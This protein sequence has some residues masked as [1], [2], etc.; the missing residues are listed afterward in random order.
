MQ[1][2]GNMGA[3]YNRGEADAEQS[4][5]GGAQAEDWLVCLFIREVDGMHHRG[6]A[7]EEKSFEGGSA[8]E[9]S[10]LFHY[11]CEMEHEIS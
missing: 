11:F 5:K 8:A 9:A 3:A 1:S 6:E 4:F 10:R 7:D 2:V